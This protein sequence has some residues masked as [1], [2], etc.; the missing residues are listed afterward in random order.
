MHYL[1]PSKGTTRRGISRRRILR[2]G[3][4]SELIKV[5]INPRSIRIDTGIKSTVRITYRTKGRH[6]TTL[7]QVRI[8]HSCWSIEVVITTTPINRRV[9]PRLHHLPREVTLPLV[10]PRGIA[11]TRYYTPTTPRHTSWEAC[12]Y[13]RIIEL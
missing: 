6:Y 4:G 10:N 9:R 2:I 8:V 13:S 12:G 7:T 11:I 3:G 5:V 1:L